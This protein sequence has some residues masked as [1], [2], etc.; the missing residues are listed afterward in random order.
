M[1]QQPNADV[2]FSLKSIAVP[3]FGP[4]VLYG[5]ANGAILPVIAFS[6]RDL[7]AS[8][9]LSGLI[10]ALIGIGSLFSNV[11]AAMI[12]TRFGE[13]RAIVGAAAFS[14]LAL[15]LC[16]FSIHI[17]MLGLG[18]LMVG[19]GASVFTLARQTYLIEAVPLSMRARAMS[20]LA[21]SNRIGVFI[22]PFAG[23]AL[24]HF[25]GL[26]GAYWIALTAMVGAGWLA[27]TMPELKVH[28][29]HDT[30]PLIKPTLISIFR[31]HAKVFVTLGLGV[32]LVSALRASRQVVIPLWADQLGLNPA[33]ASLI[34]G[35]SAAIDMA[36]FY[37][38][39]KVMDQHGRIWVAIPATVLM[40]LSLI[41]MPFTSSLT[42]FL[43]V[44]LV[45]GLGNGIGSG[46]VMTLGADS[47]PRAGRNEFLG[48]WRMIADVGSSGGPVLL[49]AI[50]AVASLA[51][52]MG[53]IG[54]LGL[55]AAGVF[56]QWVPRNVKR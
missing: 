31:N 21:G 8:I 26:S 41:A 19:M 37:P 49:S 35:L 45:I 54:V 24:I 40:G 43:I 50:A 3:A 27:M 33:T 48:I 52:G 2:P 36:V 29:S 38:A 47:S 7:D 13:R 1:S 56:W 20:T 18:V 39:G 22:G 4:S 11:P 10:V 25:I 46:I 55:V 53:A 9:A 12:T 17:W 42:A 32:L 34:Y 16:I 51:V 15:L 14:V 5:I 28:S 44:S 30:T 6:A 23:A